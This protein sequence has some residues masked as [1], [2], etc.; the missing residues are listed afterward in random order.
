MGHTCPPARQR[1]ILAWKPAGKNID[2]LDR[3]PIHRRHIPIVRHPRKVCF[4]DLRGRIF[5]L[6]M[7]HNLSIELFSDRNI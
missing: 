3:A 6:A 5:P 1:N 2:R 7:P 4:E